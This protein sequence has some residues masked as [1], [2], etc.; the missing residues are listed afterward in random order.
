L[1]LRRVGLVAGATVGA[2]ALAPAAAQAQNFT[3]NTRTDA[4]ANGCTTATNGCT[5]RD[6]VTDANAN[7]QADQITFAS[8][9]SGTVRLTQGPLVVGGSGGDA[10]P[11]TVQGPGAGV[12]TISGDANNNGTPDAG[13]SQIFTVNYV[14]SGS[15]PTLNLSGLTLSGGYTSATGGAVYLEG[16]GKLSVSNATFS[17]CK[18]ASG[19]AIG[20]EFGKYSSVSIQS[21]TISGNNTTASGGAT[22]TDG[23]L[24][25]ANSMISDNHALSGGGALSAGQ[26]YGPLS[27]TDSTISGNTAAGEGGAIGAYSLAF[28]KYHATTQNQISNTTISGNT[29]GGPG[30]GLYLD[31]LSGSGS[32]FT[33]DHST[34]SGNDAGATAQGGGIEIG[35]TI[36]GAFRTVDSTVSGNSANI[37]AGVA[38]STD[39]T[40]QVGSDG[41]ITFDNSTIAANTAAE[42]GGGMYLGIY[43]PSGGGP[44]TYSATI[45]LNSTIVGGN[46]AS[47]ASSDLDHADVATT[48]GFA[49]AFS[50]VQAPG[51]GVVSQANSILNTD[52]QLGA[53]GDN[54]GPTQTQL[55]SATSP[56]LDAGNNP[57]ALGTDQ[58][59]D[60]RTVDLSPSNA[61]DGTDIGAVEREAPPVPAP[62]SKKVKCKKKHKK[63]HKRSAESSK[64][65]HKKHKK[66]K[67]KKHKK[68]HH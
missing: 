53:L 15:H 59:G 12:V 11:V 66:C 14:A 64:K 36:E 3:V 48:G 22:F 51:D 4:A 54:G 46:T 68:K 40:P 25:I 57:L 37:G 50:L 35:Y 49:L 55:P 1:K 52:P 7:G 47:G 9:L 20:A 13:D 27:I 63:K 31:G 41:S 18:A 67:K 58:R 38:I 17:G 39:N 30:G 21:S 6:A 61:A 60:P 42:S 23:R 34:I 28:A 5:L 24:T 2:F 32:S 43:G 29:A 65:K 62:V 44:Y 33:V 8:G 56:A 45:P 19:G 16:G 26:K 10:N